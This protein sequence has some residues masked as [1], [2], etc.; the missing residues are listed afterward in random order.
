MQELARLE[1]IARAQNTSLTVVIFSTMINFP[2]LYYLLAET[3]LENPVV[4]S[5]QSKEI[6]L[7]KISS[8]SMDHVVSVL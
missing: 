7:I 3:F 4:F 6:I 8:I 1:F 2:L 5:K